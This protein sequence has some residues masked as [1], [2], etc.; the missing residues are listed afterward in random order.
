M[1]YKTKEM[2]L[3]SE[4]KSNLSLSKRC[5]LLCFN[6]SS[7]YITKKEKYIDKELISDIEKIYE[8]KPFYGYRRVL[9]N[10]NELGHKVGKKKVIKLRKELNLKTI[11][12]RSCTTIINKEHKKYNYLL[13]GL[14]INKPNKVWSIDITYLNLNGTKV[15]FSGII[16]WYSRKILSYRIS[17]TLDTNFCIETLEEAIYKYGKPEIFNSDQGSQFTSEKFTSKLL[18]YGIKISMNGKGRW[19]DNILIERFFRTFKYENIFLKKYETMRD[20]KEGVSEYIIFYNSQRYHSSLFYQTPDQVYFKRNYLEVR[21]F[22]KIDKDLI[23]KLFIYQ[24][25]LVKSNNYFNK[26]DI[27]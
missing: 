23:L 2:I 1:D 13:S 16:D 3:K 7:Y 6:R 14:E 5:N 4:D 12:P 27:A 24:N 18:S 15:Y 22:Y 17:N 20:L 10:L 25:I 9:V 26:L 11:Y 21:N 19:A 8:D